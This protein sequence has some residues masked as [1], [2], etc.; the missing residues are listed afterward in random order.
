MKKI[1]IAAICAVVGIIAFSC[2]SA[3]T[4]DEAETKSYDSSAF[5]YHSLIGAVVD[6]SMVKSYDQTTDQIAYDENQ[7]IYTLTN[8]DYTTH[9]TLGITGDIYL[10]NSITVKYTSDGISGLSSGEVTMEVIKVD[11]IS[12]RYWLW[13]SSTGVGFIIDFTL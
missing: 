2:E 13:S 1:A 9:F 3:N 12:G 6:G 10:E 8:N 4:T 11:S 7:T 5:L